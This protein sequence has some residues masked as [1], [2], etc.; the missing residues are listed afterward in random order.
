VSLLSRG[1]LPGLRRGTARE[2]RPQSVFRKSAR[3]GDARC[4]NW[5]TP[6]EGKAR[7]GGG[8]PPPQPLQRLR[9]PWWSRCVV[10][11]PTVLCAAWRVDSHVRLFWVC[12]RP[13]R[14]PRRAVS[15]PL[16]WGNSTPTHR[17]HPAPGFLPK[18]VDL[19][20]LTQRFIVPSSWRQGAF[21]L[22]CAANFEK[23][24]HRLCAHWHATHLR[25]LTSILRYDFTQKGFKPS[26][27]GSECDP[28]LAASLLYC[29]HH[30]V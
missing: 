5:N 24:M 3:E 16:A 12:A 9:R 20:R 7:G 30:R 23:A 14:P 18:P 26:P 22:R 13:P 1:A 11:H 25:Q 21:S 17:V 2:G 27:P 6:H 28:N 29:L 8:A 19:L 4:W 10:L 15:A